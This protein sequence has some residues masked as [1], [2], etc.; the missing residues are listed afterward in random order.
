MR[1]AGDERRGDGAALVRQRAPDAFG[2]ARAQRLQGHAPRR[3][4]SVVRRRDP[5][6]R[7]ERVAHPAQAVEP[8]AA[9][10]IE[11]A[12]QDGAGGGIST[13]RRLSHAPGIAAA[14]SFLSRTRTRAGVASAASP[15]I[16]SRPITSRAPSGSGSTELE[17]SFDRDGPEPLLQ[18][19]RRDEHRTALAPPRSRASAT[20]PPR[21]RKAR[22]AAATRARGRPPPAAPPR[23]RASQAA[24]PGARN[25]GRCRSPE[26][27]EARAAS[28]RARRGRRRRAARRSAFPPAPS[29]GGAPSATSGSAAAIA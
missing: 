2:D 3:G 25:K 1:V 4:A 13:A 10:E 27:P 16:A 28:A 29:A 14:S 23:G 20:A 26:A 21:P 5:A 11:R 9:L 12:R 17:P 18:H 7:A 22:A 15:A 24:R 6:R 19:R 8:G